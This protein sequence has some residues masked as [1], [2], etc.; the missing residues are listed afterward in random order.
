MKS[1]IKTRS[2][3]RLDYNNNP[4]NQTY[5]K[6]L[7]PSSIAALWSS[8]SHTLLTSPCVNVA[9]HPSTF[10]ASSKKKKK[11]R[12]TFHPERVVSHHYI[13]GQGPA[14]GLL[15]SDVALANLPQS[16]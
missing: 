7:S 1:S 5:H 9:V 3:P 4:K 2:S 15:R 11:N 14:D 12:L 8:S 6:P 10:L 16:Q 13:N